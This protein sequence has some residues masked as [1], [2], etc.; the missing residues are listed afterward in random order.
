MAG[1]ATEKEASE[2]LDFVKELREDALNRLKKH[3]ADLPPTKPGLS[4]AIVT[5]NQGSRLRLPRFVWV[6]WLLR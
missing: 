4:A 2:L 6:T 3:R 5:Q 1:V